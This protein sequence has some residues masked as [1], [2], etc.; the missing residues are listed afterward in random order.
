[1]ATTSL[2]RLT[3]DLVAQIGQFTDPL[4]RAERKAKDSTDKM[5]KSF[6]SFGDQ[7]KDA[8]GGT[9]LGASIDFLT[10]KLNSLQGGALVA[11]GAISGMVVGGLA[12]GTVGLAKMSIEAAKADVQL[13]VLANRA[14]TSVKNFQILE[15]ASL[16]FGVSQD[17]LG[18]ILADVQEKLGEF[19][20][21]KGGGGAD[22][23]D[24]L[25][26]NTKMTEAQ[27]K[28]FSKTLQGKD[29]IGA[30][31]AI[32]NKLDDLDVSKQE[33]RFIFESLASDLGNL[34]PLFAEN[35]RLI[36][37]F[38][39][40]LEDAGVIKTEEAI[41]KS[42]LLAAQT[43]AVNL[44]FQGWKNQLV[45]GFMPAIVDVANAIFGTSKNGIQL[46]E[47][48]EGIG[49]VLRYVTKVALGASAVFVVTGKLI[50][51][52]A[53]SIAA[54]KGEK[55]N[56][57]NIMFDDIQETLADYGA[58]IESLDNST[59]KSVK[60]NNNLVNSILAINNASNQTSSG[61]KTNTE[62]AKE[63]EK[64]TKKQAEA[65]AKLAK[66]Q[67]NLNKMVGATALTGLRIK[68][69]E[70]FAGGNV[71]AYT[72]NF[73]QMTQSAFGSNLGR[74][75]AFNDLYH[76]GTNSK[77]ATG[78][79]FDFTIAD[80]KKSG[81]AVKQLE[82]IAKR[83]GYVV[84]ILDEYR[85][86]SSRATG[87]HIH[88]SVLGFKGTAQMQ[89]DAQAELDIIGK[90][91]EDA[92]KI[93]TEMAKKQISIKLKLG[94]DL[95]KIEIQNQE[96]IDE[97]NK[98]FTENDP[99]RQKYLDLQKLVYQKDLEEF[100]K[101]QLQK[102]YDQLNSIKSIEGQIKGLSG[103]S[104]DVFAKASM[105]A[106]DYEQWVLK[107]NRD[108]AKKALKDD[109]VTTEQNISTSSAYSTD[110]ERYD[111]LLE[112]HKNYREGMFALDVQYAQQSKELVQSQKMEQLN[113]WGGILSNAQNTFAQLTQSAKDGAGEQSTVYRTMFALQ[114]GFSVASSLVAAWTAYAQA[115]AD[116]S[117]MTTEMKFAGA[118]SVMAALAP[119]L[120]TISSVGFS[121]G[122]YTG[123]GG[124]FDIAGVVHRGEG[125]L[126][127]EEI[128]ALGGPS[129]FM[130][131]RSMIKNGFADGG[132]V[133]DGGIKV[134]NPQQNNDLSRYVSESISNQ[135]SQPQTVENIVKFVM[136]KDE[137]EAKEHLYGKDGEK[138]FLYHARR[139]GIIRR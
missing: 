24:A 106:N 25:K 47:V 6:K 128:S 69:S 68:S 119:A 64:A 28:S 14:N 105:S 71:R 74:F 41:K 15:Q 27:I 85:N 75:T 104:D 109:L 36:N 108:N 118:A 46:Q 97:I 132:F 12:L 43:Q 26:N 30:I 7:L 113:L 58:R 44:Q 114:Q 13:Q 78:N 34:A 86:P 1:M 35:G 127:Q 80:A 92:L 8:F 135:N 10:T 67:E 16:G 4:D 61:L 116:P 56:T 40:A 59:N 102:Q 21:T 20:A 103:N 134:L 124:K 117:K 18:S 3:L 52:I 73:A 38:G 50:G 100:R 70:A 84:K 55:L 115:F 133:G 22:F 88:V 54:M 53:A 65:K 23:F 93:F 29:G 95:S 138:A 137:E 96:S 82:D 94:D 49:S 107:N 90:T 77:H 2:G 129:G 91:N 79:A 9:Q 98:A 120:A 81:E 89:K 39:T 123:N 11:T 32:S 42:Q 110:D 87:G 131:L 139:N 125:V 57:A 63:N 112:A 45:T 76:K 111:A 66:E 5:S 19:S 62:D 33:R 136:V 60:S 37:D 72:A 83:Y 126:S 101:T 51:G 121:S 17:Q 122:G 130:A 99:N 31:Q 48:G